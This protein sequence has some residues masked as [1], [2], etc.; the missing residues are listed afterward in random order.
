[1][2]C[3]EFANNLWGNGHRYDTCGL[4]TTIYTPFCGSGFP[5]CG[6]NIVIPGE[7]YANV[8]EFMGNVTSY[9]FNQDS[10][11]F[12]YTWLVV[13]PDQLLPGEMCFNTGSQISYFG[14]LVI[15]ILCALF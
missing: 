1:L 15:L 5:E 14:L 3:E 10:G 2:I 7:A 9:G 4:Q 12:S 8:V 11:W 6:N 13:T